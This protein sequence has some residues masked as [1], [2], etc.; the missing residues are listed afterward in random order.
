MS[1]TSEMA[2]VSAKGGFHL[3]WGLVISSAISA[4]GAIIIA[5]LLSPSEYGL[6]SIALTAPSLIAM[7]RDWGINSA[8]VRYTCQYK[9]ENKTANVRDILAAGLV[10]ETVTGSALSIGLFMMSG[11]VASNVFQRPGI[12]PLI[13]IMSFMILADAL[14]VALR[15]AFTGLEKQVPNSLI[16]ICQS[17]VK[18]LLVSTLVI[19]GHGAYGATVG[20]VISALTATLIG[21]LLAW[22][23]YKNLPRTDSGEERRGI[24][25]N[26]RL[27]FRYGLPLSIS[28]ILSGFLL[29]F[30]NFLVVIYASDT[31]MGNYSVAS[32]VI[33]PITF[34]ATPIATMLFPAFS[35]LNPQKE[36]ESLQNVFQ[37]SIKYAALIVVPVATAIMVLSQPAVSTLFGGQYVEAPLY[38]ALLAINYLYTAFGSLSTGNLIN[39]QGE[40]KLNLK[41]GLINIAVGLPLS[42]VLIPRF[43]IIGLISTSLVAGLPSLIVAL[44]WIRTNYKVSM[45]VISSAKIL[46]SSLIAAIAT[47]LILS[48]L[49]FNSWMKLIIGIAVFLPTFLL[50]ILLTRT[51]DGSDI[52]NL[53]EMTSGLGPL[54]KMLDLFLNIFEEFSTRL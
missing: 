20:T 51:I 52:S 21:A 25:E 40:T 28:A 32:N 17:T 38:L 12:T 42:I 23:I 24:S 15:A 7:F 3:F 49:S 39:G 45:N 47:T 27:M 1:K 22:R 26:I 11:F 46:L 35:K 41:L 33:V 5:R 54:S 31:A 44:S 30:Y 8:L 43:G 13:Q 4:I 48:Q 19:L 29:Q 9:A 36:R 2:K 18:M 37:Y 10:F 53:R 16:L 50:S 14:M 6:Y 34:F